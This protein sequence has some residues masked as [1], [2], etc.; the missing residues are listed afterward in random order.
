MIAGGQGERAPSET[1]D[2]AD[3]EPTQM[4]EGALTKPMFEDVSTANAHVTEAMRAAAMAGD[5]TNPTAVPFTDSGSEEGKP[6]TPHAPSPD[7]K[8]ILPEG[9]LFA[10]LQPREMPRNQKIALALAGLMVLLWALYF[11]VQM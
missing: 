4:F 7:Q 11:V 3:F 10:P 5:L 1:D 9:E 8:V 2:E 6:K